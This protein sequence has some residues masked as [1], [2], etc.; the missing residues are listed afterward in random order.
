MEIDFT[1]PVPQVGQLPF[2]DTLPDIWSQEVY[3]TIPQTNLPQ[4]S[5]ANITFIL[6]SGATSHIICDRSLFQEG[7]IRD[8]DKTIT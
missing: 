1:I 5:I 8:F 2:E 6:D 7:N 4:A 3:I